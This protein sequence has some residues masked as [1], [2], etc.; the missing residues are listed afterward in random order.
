MAFFFL[1]SREET[2]RPTYVI[3]YLRGHL[4]R[5]QLYFQSVCYVCYFDVK[6]ARIFIPSDTWLHSLR[7]RRLEVSQSPSTIPMIVV[8]R[9]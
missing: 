8:D 9:C 6:W 2:A 4:C 3:E 5:I 1:V 7:P